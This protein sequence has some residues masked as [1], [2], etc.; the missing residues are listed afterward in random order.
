MYTRHDKRC[1]IVGVGAGLQLSFSL[2]HALLAS[3]YVLRHV[4]GIVRCIPVDT[5]SSSGSHWVY[6]CV[7]AASSAASLN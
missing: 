1:V 2:R 3:L 7:S 4:G 6:P 5:A